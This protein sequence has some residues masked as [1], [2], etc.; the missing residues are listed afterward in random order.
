MSASLRRVVI[1][2]ST[3]SVGRQALEVIAEHPEHLKVVGLV[4]GSDS[5]AL[6]DQA[7]RFGVERTGL[8]EDA[9]VELARSADADVVLNAVVGAAGLRASIAALEAGKVLALANKESLVAGG[10]A[11][12]AAA[13]AGGGHI[14]PVDSEHAALAQCLHGKEAG[15]V[16][17]ITLTASGGPFRTRRDLS[18]VTPEE[19]LAHP[20]WSMGAK[21]TI[22]CATMMNKGLE[23]IEAHHLFGFPFERID[24]VV[25][26]QSIV[27]GMVEMS[28]GSMLMHAAA[29]DMRLPIQAALL[30][31][32]EHASRYG[33]VDLVAA[34][35][36]EFERFDP[37]RFPAVELAYEAGRRG[38]TYPAVL[39]AANEV[40]VEAFLNARLGFLEIATVVENALE[41]HEPGDSAELTEVLDADTWA[42]VRAEHSIE[43]HSF[44]LVG[45]RP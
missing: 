15:E 30:G 42:R 27:H 44:S 9:A 18:G 10:R 23:V 1:L 8:G 29:P 31:D 16:R 20:T 17:R 11:C 6:R 36:L 32:P 43:A 28:D 38:G 19:A 2:G 22:D 7:E 4:A 14:V 13:R 40:A 12:A 34:G 33:A 39:N 25:H 35:A 21:I 41:A 5:R 45:G 3:G 26:P 37:S 24:V